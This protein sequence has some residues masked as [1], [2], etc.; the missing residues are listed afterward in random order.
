MEN[1]GRLEMFNLARSTMGYKYISPVRCHY[2][3]EL[4]KDGAIVSPVSSRSS[5]GVNELWKAQVTLLPLS[6]R[7]SLSRSS[8]GTV[9]ICQTFGVK[10]VLG[11]FCLGALQ[12]MALYPCLLQYMQ[13]LL[14]KRYW[15]CSG[16]SFPCLL[17]GV[18]RCPWVVLIS[19]LLFSADNLQIQGLHP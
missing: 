4:A 17:N 19:A 14:S 1:L 13:R 16:V 8:S 6:F 11:L 10:E 5:R 12:S 18:Q 3:R 2:R 7:L 9:S 15:C